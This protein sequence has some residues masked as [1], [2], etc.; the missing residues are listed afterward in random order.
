MQAMEKAAEM[1]NIRGHLE[2]HRLAELPETFTLGERMVTHEYNCLPKGSTR[3]DGHRILMVVYPGIVR[4][5][6]CARDR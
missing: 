6:I 5:Y 4:R 2:F 3:L 1:G